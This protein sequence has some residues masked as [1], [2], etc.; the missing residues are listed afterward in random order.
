MEKYS[1]PTVRKL[2]SSAALL[3]LLVGCTAVPT[4]VTVPATS[5]SP[6]TPVVTTTPDAT[7]TGTPTSAAASPTSPASTATATPTPTPSDTPSAAPIPKWR[8][9][10]PASWKLVLD[11]DFKGSKMPKF[12]GYRQSNIYDAG[13]R[14]CSAPVDDNTEFRDDAAVLS[15]SEASPKVTDKVIPT[16]KAKQ[17]KAGE[18]VVGCPNGVFDNAMI[19]TEGRFTMNTGMVAARVKFPPDQG[20]HAGVWL[21]SHSQ[22]EIDIIETY[23]FGRGV[24]N[25]AHLRGKR[26]PVS[27]AKAY[28]VPRVVA[29]RDW[30]DQWHTVS[31]EWT[32]SKIVFRLDGQVTRE[33]KQRTVKA[34]YFVVLSML[35]SDWESHRMME[36]RPRPGSGVKAG[37]LTSSQLPFGMEVDWV[38]AWKRK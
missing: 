35:S 20:A 1:G 21:Q 29:N 15:V 10:D 19:S 38:R 8:D 28:V 14:W 12:W 11:T 5:P 24:T 17:S 22:Q 25:V 30:W 23:G 3:V 26:F 16:A 36:P 2:G 34:D 9:P 13:G 4:P 31:V 7:P 27:G 18:K 37:D 32:Q 6:S 33:V